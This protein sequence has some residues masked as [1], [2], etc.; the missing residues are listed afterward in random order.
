LRYLKPLKKLA[1]LQP[2]V[3]INDQD[4]SYIVDFPLTS[5]QLSRMYRNITNE[6]LAH[7]GRISTL[8]SLQLPPQITDE[9]FKRLAGLTQIQQLNLWETG[10]TDAGLSV[11][12]NM[13]QVSSIQLPREASD[14]GLANLVEMKR[15][16]I[17]CA[18]ERIGDGSIVYL[19]KLTNLK[20][21]KLPHNTRFTKAGMDELRRHFP[22]LRIDVGPPPVKVP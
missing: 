10:V 17:I 18:H 20:T 11:L 3:S 13:K 7:V 9:G 1:G 6:G 22:R 2:P 16:I 12:R 15:L 4:L 14:H 8:R 21:L 19:K 5:L